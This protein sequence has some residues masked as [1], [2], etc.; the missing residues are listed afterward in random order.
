MNQ[1]CFFPNFDL[2]LQSAV[3]LQD[4]RCVILL[5]N[6]KLHVFHCV[7]IFIH[8]FGIDFCDDGALLTKL[9]DSLLQHCPN[10]ERICLFD[11][12]RRDE[13]FQSAT[14][15]SESLLKYV[16]G[17]KKLVAFYIISPIIE[18]TLQ[19]D[20]KSYLR[21][22]SPPPSAAL[23]VYIGYQCP[24]FSDVPA[25]LMKEFVYPTIEFQYPLF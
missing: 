8:R 25:I 19:R 12:N 7:F 13:S 2:F 17:F 14:V 15:T 4:F 16:H 20:I 22:L 9:L 21:Q 18:F 11:T 24:N 5:H 3:K 10:I 6:H 1:E 23:R